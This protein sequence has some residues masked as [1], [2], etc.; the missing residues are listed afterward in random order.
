MNGPI[1]TIG[2]SIPSPVDTAA[3]VLVTSIDTVTVGI[4]ETG[5][6]VTC[7][8]TCAGQPVSAA[9]LRPPRVATSQSVSQSV[10]LS[11]CL[12]VVSGQYL[13]WLRPPYNLGR[14]RQEQVATAR[15]HSGGVGSSS[16]YPAVNCVAKHRRRRAG[17]AA[18]L[19]VRRRARRALRGC[20]RGDGVHL[21]A[22]DGAG[23]CLAE[24]RARRVRVRPGTCNP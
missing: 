20:R 1:L 15:R 13:S 5:A 8:A 16:A 14:G 22:C 24:V 6:T 11:V 3:L 2:G 10:C 4:V 7:T 12:S 17:V 19:A 21:R 9:V 18:R 23:A